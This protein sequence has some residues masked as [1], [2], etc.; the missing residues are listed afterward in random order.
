MPGPERASIWKYV[1]ELCKTVVQCCTVPSRCDYL[2]KLNIHEQI[3]TDVQKFILTHDLKDLKIIETNEIR[4][5][6]GKK[7]RMACELYKA[8]E[9]TVHSTTIPYFF[10]VLNQ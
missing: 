8:I 3:Y 9:R 1:D 4:R 6:G 2:Y 7:S 10:K 5:V